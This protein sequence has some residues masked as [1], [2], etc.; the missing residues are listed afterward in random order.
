MENPFIRLQMAL[1]E[2]ALEKLKNSHVAVFG[3]GGVGS[4]TAEAL[5]VLAQLGLFAAVNEGALDGGADVRHVDTDLMGPARLQTAADVG[6]APVAADHLPVGHGVPGIALGDAHLLPVGGMPPDGGVHGAGI[7]PE[8]ADHDALVSPR[9]GVILKLG[10]QHGVGV[11]IFGNRQQAG[12]GLVDAVDDARAQLAVDAG[13]VIALGVHQAVD[14]RVVLVSGGGVDH[15]PLGLVDDQHILVLVDDLQ[16][17]LR[18]LDIHAYRLGDLH[19]DGVARLQAVIFLGIFAVFQHIS[20]LDELLGGTA[21]HVSHPGEEGIQTLP[22][23][24]S[25]KNHSR[26]SHK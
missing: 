24:I 17:H 26:S 14:Q 10:S 22:G 15:Q 12:G 3:I 20:L 4:Y 18:G 16:V 9:H 7:L 2:D 21:A 8:G 11:V 19:L 13:E 25:G 23:D 5:A 6:I 1:G